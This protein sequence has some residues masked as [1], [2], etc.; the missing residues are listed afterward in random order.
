MGDVINLNKFRKAKAR[1]DKAVTAQHNRSKHGRSA[2]DTAR[3][4]EA[5]EKLERTLTGKHLEPE[6]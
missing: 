6:E 3:Q 5:R 4:A 1:A 2:A